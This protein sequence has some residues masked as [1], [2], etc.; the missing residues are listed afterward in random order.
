MTLI[1]DIF[2]IAGALGAAFYCIVLSR[3]LSRFGSLESGMGGAI[4]ALSSQVSE[5][6]ESLDRARKDASES[7]E[8]LSDITHK[9]EEAAARLELLL[10]SLHDLEDRAPVLPVAVE[11][12]AEI[13]A[14]T[15]DDVETAAPLFVSMGRSKAMKEALG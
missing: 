13:D 1:A 12:D 2:L 14:D 3:K 8:S 4:A 15:T 6:N 7:A 9:A 10:A 11:E 5:M